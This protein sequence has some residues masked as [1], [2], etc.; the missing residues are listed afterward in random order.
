MDPA[1]LLLSLSEA[2][3]RQRVEVASLLSFNPQFNQGEQGPCLEVLKS[4][5]CHPLAG[6]LHQ[7]LFPPYIP[8]SHLYK[9]IL[10][11]RFYDLLEFFWNEF[12]GFLYRRNWRNSLFLNYI[13]SFTIKVENWLAE[14]FALSGGLVYYL[15]KSLVPLAL[16]K[17]MDLSTRGIHLC[18][19][20]QPSK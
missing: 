16:R 19:H 11:L 9:T 14:V 2:S 8:F 4:A 1:F 20:P 18:I 12:Q 6:W 7:V 15:G 5:S 10:V 13:F 3:K 17:E